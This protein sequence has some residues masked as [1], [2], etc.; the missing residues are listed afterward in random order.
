[1]EFKQGADV[2]TM[3]GDK[4]GRIERV[5]IDPRT[6]DITHIVVAQGFLFSEDR[7]V[8]IE[9]IDEAA[10]DR[11]TLRSRLDEDEVETL[12]RFEEVDFLP[13]TPPE[14]TEEQAGYP[15]PVVWYPTAGIAWWTNPGLRG[16]YT[17][18]AF[19]V[20]EEENVPE[21]TIGLKHGARV[22]AADG[23]HVGNVEQVITAGEDNRATH[24][25]ISQGMLFPEKK[26]VPTTWINAVEEDRVVLA[27]GS[28]LLEQV[29]EYDG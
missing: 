10:G 29:R 28:T 16:F 8:P 18:P 20:E 22:I 6:R 11:I 13:L 25:V 7:V 23:E 12:P 14:P 24:L 3:D 5:V 1:M 15:N 26:L 21:G 27:V 17:R 19:V 4:V 9:W 2:V